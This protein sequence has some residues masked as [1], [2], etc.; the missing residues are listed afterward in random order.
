MPHLYI[1]EA[2]VERLLMMTDAA[3]RSTSALVT[4]TLCARRTCHEGV[5]ESRLALSICWV[6]PTARKTSLGSKLTLPLQAAHA[7]TSCC[8][9][10][11]RVNCWQLSRRI[12]L[13]R[14]ARGRPARGRPA[15]WRR[16]CWHARGCVGP[17][18]HWCRATGFHAGRCGSRR[19]VTS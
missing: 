10:P 18:R 16:G 5:F 6:R 14:Y 15:V 8:S 1:S 17:C 3:P 13:A 7:F 2:G 19:A 12:V 9:R 4:G 11:C